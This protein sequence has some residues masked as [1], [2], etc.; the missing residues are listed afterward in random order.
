MHALAAL[1]FV[2]TVLLPL[3]ASAAIIPTCEHDAVT[4]MPSLT[5]ELLESPFESPFESPCDAPDAAIAEGSAAPICDPSG[6]SAVAPPRILPITDARIDAVPNCGDSSSIGPMIGP[7][8]GDHHAMSSAAIVDQAMLAGDLFVPPAP[9][10]E[11]VDPLTPAGGPRAAV[12][13]DVY[14]PPR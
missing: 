14:H 7:R 2:V 3:R 11:T 1:A 8:S 12:R 9:F 5:R 13:A 6:A 4:A 10:V